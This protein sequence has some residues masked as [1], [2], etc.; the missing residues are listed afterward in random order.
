MKVLI[1]GKKLAY[2]VFSLTK[3]FLLST[4]LILSSCSS[5]P[6]FKK[7]DCLTPVNSIEA[8]FNNYALVE[9]IYSAKEKRNGNFIYRLHFPRYKSKNNEFGSLWI[10]D[11]TIKV[12]Y[13]YC[14]KG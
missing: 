4:L 3:I 7:G 5:D 12:D 1:L 8:W 2:F 9:D 13:S 6:K 14:K 10:E 11:N